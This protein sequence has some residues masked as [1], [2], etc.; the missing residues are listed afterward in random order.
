MDSGHAGPGGYAERVIHEK[1][2]I[3]L[4]LIP[5]GKLR[6]GSSDRKLSANVRPE[7]EVTIPQAF[8][9]GK[10]EVTNGQYRRFMQARPDYKGEAD[11]DPGYELYLLHFKGKSVMSA[12][13]ECPVV[14]VS[15]RNGQKFCE[16]AG[17]QLPS[18]AQWEYACRAG[19]TTHYSFG[20]DEKEELHK[21]AWADLAARPPYPPGSDQA[22][23]L[24]GSVRHAWQRLARPGL[25][26]RP[27][28]RGM[29]WAAHDAW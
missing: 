18:E 4:I 10:T 23:Q 6:M 22:A 7:H 2:G 16:W 15:W 8:Y 5:A 29:N 24:V 19:T 25:P 17:L 1:T 11:T 26:R 9:M 14:W 12:E 3:E 20:D 21:H 27:A 28:S 13:D